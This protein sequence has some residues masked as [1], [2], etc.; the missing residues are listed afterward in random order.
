MR[1][2]VIQTQALHIVGPKNDGHEHYNDL[3]E[4]GIS[5]FLVILGSGSLYF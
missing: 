2:K 4:K 3:Q 5:N 1:I